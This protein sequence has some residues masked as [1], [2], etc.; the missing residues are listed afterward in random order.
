MH[1]V[2]EA[3]T[4]LA[5]FASWAC[6]EKVKPHIKGIASHLRVRLRPHGDAELL[7]KMQQREALDSHAKTKLIFSFLTWT[8]VPLHIALNWVGHCYNRAATLAFFF[9]EFFLARYANNYFCRLL[10]PLISLHIRTKAQ[11]KTGSISN[12]A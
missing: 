4:L 7:R 2:S 10:L 3:Q 1:V 11:W 5:V 12:C 9:G 6:Y 8:T